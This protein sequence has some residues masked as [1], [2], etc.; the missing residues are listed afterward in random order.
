VALLLAAWLAWQAWVERGVPITVLLDR[1]HNL[2][3]GDDLR[4]RGIT[5]G[6][7]VSVRLAREVEGIVV[8]A[9][10]VSDADRLARAGSRFWVVRP[11]LG[12]SGV[13]GIETL[14]G[15]RYLAVLPGEG[16]RQRS[17]VGLSEPP[18]VQ[19]MQPGDLEVIVTADEL[20]TLRRGAPVTYRRVRVGTVVSAGLASDGG[21]VEA[22]LHIEQAYAQLVRLQTRFWM[23]EGLE[24]TVGLSG[25]SVELESLADLL[26]G[27]VAMATPPV[28]GEVVRTGHRFTLETQPPED[29]ISWQPMAAIGSS[30]LPPGAPRPTPLRAVIRWKQG[31]I[32]GRERSRRGWVIQTERGLLGPAHLLRPEDGAD[33]ESVQL[34]I[35]GALLAAGE[36]RWTLRGLTLL[37]VRLPGAPWPARLMRQP[38]EPEDCLA[39]SDPNEAP[40]PLAVTR[41][42][43]GDEGWAIDPAVPLDE[44]WHG[45]A[46][47]AR[48]DGALIGLLLVTG[49]ESRVALLPPADR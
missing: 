7:V 49:G 11:Q 40:L 38:S 44:S 45:A 19:E 15:P 42:S 16:D 37:D 18:V 13:E 41:M 6:Q 17:F 26:V 5:V 23:H 28:A 3:P 2:R 25:V 39:F 21:A 32:I 22:R 47:V 31:R 9:R 33:R 29:W 30:M 4:Y 20:G 14:V 12:L 35:A 36:P 48:G 8:E 24:A 34:E 10:L 46:V 1:G 27:G 43:A